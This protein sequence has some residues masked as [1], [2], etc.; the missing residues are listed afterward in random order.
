MPPR[1]Q[2]T[3]QGPPC[4]SNDPLS[5]PRNMAGTYSLG[6]NRPRPMP[7]IPQGG[8]WF[9]PD[10]ASGWRIPMPRNPF[11]DWRHQLPDH[12]ALPLPPGQSEDSHPI[13]VTP[14]SRL[15]RV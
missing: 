13:S 9:P 1:D 6:T 2:A 14:L 7:P 11:K 15:Q 10:L 8:Y 3:S 4:H 12:P 5:L